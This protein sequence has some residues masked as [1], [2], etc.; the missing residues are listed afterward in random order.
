MTITLKGVTS[1]VQRRRVTRSVNDDFPLPSRCLAIAKWASKRRAR[2]SAAK[3]AGDACRKTGSSTSNRT[4][5]Q[6][7]Q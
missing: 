6:K 1:A 3:Y 5:L 2:V 7:N 4:T